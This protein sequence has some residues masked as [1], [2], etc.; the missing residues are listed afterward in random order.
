MTTIPASS[1]VPTNDR[2]GTML[3]AC[4]LVAENFS[5]AAC[6]GTSQPPAGSL[7]AWAVGLYAGD[8][9]TGIISEVATLGS[10][11][12]VKTALCAVDGTQLAVSADDHLSYASTGLKPTAFAAPYTVTATGLYYL[13]LVTV[14]G[15]SPTWVGGPGAFQ[16]A[17]PDRAGFAVQAARQSGRTDM[18]SP[19]V[20]SSGWGTLAPLWLAAY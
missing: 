8:V 18:P 1:R 15:T 19:L 17:L 6:S 4:G 7:V 16:L 14:G 2:L 12:L 5:R 13:A 10:P 11:T 9:V 20:L 3:A